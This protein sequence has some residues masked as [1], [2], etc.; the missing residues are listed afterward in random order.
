MRGNGLFTYALLQSL[1]AKPASRPRIVRPL[2]LDQDVE[3]FF[4]PTNPNSA[5]QKLLALLAERGDAVA[6]QEPVFM[7]ARRQGIR[8]MTIRTV[9]P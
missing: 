9:L 7:P 4:D 2:D 3:K 6:M 1:T 8:N 5:A